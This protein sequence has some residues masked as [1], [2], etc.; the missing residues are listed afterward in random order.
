MNKNNEQERILGLVES[1]KV[2][3]VEGER[4]LSSL[5]R[6][7]LD[8]GKCPFCAETI[9]AVIDV[10]PECGS[11]LNAYTSSQAMWRS[12]A[13]FGAL[14]GLGKF[15]V[16]YMFMIC[17][18]TILLPPWCFSLRVELML[19]VL[20]IVAAVLICKGCRSG[21]VLGILWA[22]A[23][24]VMVVVNGVM[25]NRQLLHLGITWTANGNGMGFNLVG[26]VLFVLL[27]KAASRKSEFR[28]LN[29]LGVPVLLLL[30]LGVVCF[31]SREAYSSS[32]MSEQI[33]E[34]SQQF[35]FEHEE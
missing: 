33:I 9:P 20:G 17:G 16:C 4:L 11:A 22:G 34:N 3:P 25:I 14:G 12:G 29:E 31:T 7:G 27:I 2:T 10:C 1:G 5:E 21:W 6:H 15:L 19:A 35:R 28:G 24:I 32:S 26:L 13:G 23:Q 8:S 18:L 30:I